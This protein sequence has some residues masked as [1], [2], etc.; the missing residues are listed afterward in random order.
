[1]GDQHDRLAQ[2]LARVPQEIED[3][4]SGGVVQVAG[5]LIG[6]Q[7]RGLGGQCTRQRDPLLLAGGELVRALPGKGREAHQLE[8]RIHPLPMLGKRFAGNQERECHV[9][10]HVQERD[11]VEELEDESG[12]G[13]AR[14]RGLLVIELADVDP[15]DDHLAAGRLIEA[16]EEMQHGRLSGPGA[17]HDRHELALGDGQGYPSQSLDRAATER[18]ALD[19]VARLEDRRHALRV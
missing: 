16:A 14:E 8:E 4:G 18:K 11:Q 3:L 7:D 6:E 1:M 12:L 5:R 17:A 19:Q 13:A 10:R 9:L 2:A 15:I